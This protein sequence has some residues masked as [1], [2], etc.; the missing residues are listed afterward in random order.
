MHL[1]KVVFLDQE[2]C[3]RLT[4]LFC[5]WPVPK[6]PLPAPMEFLIHTN[7]VNISKN[8]SLWRNDKIYSQKPLWKAC[9]HRTLAQSSENSFQ[10][11]TCNGILSHVLSCLSR[12]G[13]HGPSSELHNLQQGERRK[14]ASTNIRRKQRN[15]SLNKNK[16]YLRPLL[17]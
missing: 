6:E 10:N 8:P 2:L 5:V 14:D 12:V 7:K 4:L 13:A 11:H 17:Q 16:V 15:P 1:P 3:F 9:S